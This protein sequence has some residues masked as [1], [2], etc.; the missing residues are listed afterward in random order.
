MKVAFRAD[1]SS[2]IGL[3]HVMRCLAL[4][5]DLQRRGVDVRFVCRRLP[6]DGASVLERADMTVDWLPEPTEPAPPG[7]PWAAV[8]AEVD[9]A[10]TLAVLGAVDW[11]VVDHY[12]LD[13]GWERTVRGRADR[14]LAIDDLLD[15]TH[16]VDI[17]L[18]QNLDAP[19]R[20]VLLPNGAR[21]LLGP[22][23]ALLRPEFAE[24]R[25]SRHHRDPDVVEPRLLVFLGGSDPSSRTVAVTLALSNRLA[26]TPIDVVVA[27]SHPDLAELRAL[28]A[29]LSQVTVHVDIADM[30]SL[31]AR[32]TAMIGATGSTSWERGAAG[33]PGVTVTMA[34]NQEPIARA[35][36]RARAV[37]H[38]GPVED[39]SPEAIASMA[40]RLLGRPSLLERMARRAS[41]ICDGWGSAR[42]AAALGAPLR[43]DVLS[44]ESS[45]IDTRLASLVGG[46]RSAGHEVRTIHDPAGLERGDLAFFLSSSSL[47][48][49]DQLALHAHN[50]VVHESALPRGRGWSPL[51]WQVLEGARDIPVTLF[52]AVPAVD[53]GAIH[54]QTTIETGGYELVDEL[55]D[56]QAAATVALCERFVASYPFAL[57]DTRAQRGTPSHYRRRIP[58]DSRL[59]P[60]VS[61]REQ[62]DLLRVVDNDRYP[63]YFEI[64]GH[65]YVLR[66]ERADDEH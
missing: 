54:D 57:A 16:D 26:M 13:D 49:P 48:G 39:V 58:Q 33:L 60:D 36:R 53:A 47:V 27:R 38:L 52:E 2:A 12:G 3:G 62:F 56:L 15:R 31:M 43:I 19:E 9:A 32:A 34:S 46:W 25:A 4:A 14:L 59:D 22:R 29:R 10:Q 51:T 7:Q 8:P 20:S 64:D 42:T 1:A 30:A 45:W 55:R 66:I 17:L 44:D 18:D 24:S 5:T 6:G 11:L 23:Y 28:A 21:Q 50:L 65:R 61:I 41:R 37:I 35:L 63:G 40:E